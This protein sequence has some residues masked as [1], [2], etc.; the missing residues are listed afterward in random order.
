LRVVELMGARLHALTEADCIAFILSEIAD[1]RGGWLVTMNLNHLRSFHLLPEYRHVYAQATLIVPDG[2]PLIWASRL[3]GTALPE[4]VTGSNLI[5]SLTRAAAKHQRAIFLLGGSPE[6]AATAADILRQH[7]PTLRIA[8]VNS[9]PLGFE[10]HSNGIQSVVDALNAA[11]PDI[12]YVAL[13]TPKED[14]IIQQI[15]TQLPQT[16]LIGVGASFDF[17]AGAL[18]RAPQWVQH[19]G[20]EWLHRLLHEPRRLARR[21]LIEGLPF[22]IQL[23]LHALRQRFSGNRHERPEA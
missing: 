6:V 22:M 12:V 13:G 23:M 20:L 11:A 2:M 4:R 10:Q 9:P 1:R 3:Q 5:W 21:Y 14:R 17:V 7:N 8:G 18:P 16:F 15:R 19:A